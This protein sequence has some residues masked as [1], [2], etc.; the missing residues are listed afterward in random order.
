MIEAGLE[1]D[2]RQ[3]EHVVSALARLTTPLRPAHFS[4][5]EHVEN[6]AD[7][8]ENQA[9]L[10]A[11]LA[12]S[13][14]GL[15]LLGKGITYSIRAAPGRPLV[16]DCFLDVEPEIAMQFLVQ[17]S[18]S[19]PVFG[20]ACAPEEREHRNR[21]ATQQG[22]R[23]I[24]AWV[25]RDT[26]KYVPGLYWLTLLSDSLAKRHG[27]P[28]SALAAVAQEH[29]AL[30]LGQHLFRFYNRPED[31]QRTSIVA[32]LCASLAGVFDIEAVRPS[33]DAAKDFLELNLVLQN[34]K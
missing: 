24:E 15:F 17:M 25:G 7:R 2:D 31:W 11:F 14:S 18:A 8:I 3:V 9:R 28:V 19:Q 13:K 27:V 16:C 4:H 26:K 33:V 32:D 10:S 21:L 23:R 34:W 12:E 5:E 22:V 20:F 29:V 6:G 30:G 1:F